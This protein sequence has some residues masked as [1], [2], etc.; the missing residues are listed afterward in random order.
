MDL[1]Q[2]KAFVTVAETGSVTAAA[3][4]LNIVQPAVSRQLRLLEE[5][6]GIALFTRGRHGMELTDAGK[7]L[8]DYARRALTELDRARAEIRPSSGTVGGIVTVGL[9]PST[10][11]M[12]SSALLRAVAANYPGIRLRL[13]SGYAGHLQSW[14][15][16]G[17]VDV[18]LLYDSKPNPALKFRPLLDESLW[19]VG[20]P[21]SG[22]DKRTPVRMAEVIGRPLVLPG[23]PHGLRSLV[24][25]AARTQDIEL[26]IVAETNAMSVQK[27]LV[28]DG[29]GYT[30]LPSI[31]VVDDVDR[32]IL[33]A[34]P[35]VDPVLTRRIVLAQPAAR[36]MA[37]SVRCVTKE[38]VQCIRD[39]VERDQW[40]SAH[41]LAK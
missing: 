33:A 17:D 12:L 27:R 31:A 26:D 8:G 14:L 6:V 30:I 34:A 9:L 11:D 24:E 7:T 22:L 40:P 15:E 35:V 13:T 23:A 2:L 20:P 19:F 25:Q 18:A 1:K 37:N 36:T 4:L 41:W 16:T 5:D 29:H 21:A 39:A 32:G 3:R 28:L 38:L 10:A